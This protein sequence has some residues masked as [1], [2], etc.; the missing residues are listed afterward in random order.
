MVVVEALAVAVVAAQIRRVW[1]KMRGV[2]RT[3]QA[4]LGSE[5]SVLLRAA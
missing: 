1:K 2:E 3:E 5:R 4:T